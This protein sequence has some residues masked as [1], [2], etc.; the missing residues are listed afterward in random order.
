MKNTTHRLLACTCARCNAS[1]TII[2]S[3]HPKAENMLCDDCD[4]ADATEELLDY[5]AEAKASKQYL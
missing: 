1:Y 5:R 3:A 2:S 4:F